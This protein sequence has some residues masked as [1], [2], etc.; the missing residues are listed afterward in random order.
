MY[1]DSFAV[2][3]VLI[4]SA[5]LA[6][7]L[8][9]RSIFG[10]CAAARFLTDSKKGRLLRI[11]AVVKRSSPTRSR[12]SHG[13]AR[14]VAEYPIGEKK[15]VGRMLCSS[16]ERLTEGQTVKV[17]VSERKSGFFVVDERQIKGAVFACAVMCFD[18]L[19]I[20]SFL[21]FVAVINCL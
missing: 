13:S 12:N 3:A 5:L 4:A 10:L 21:S 11:K 2:R 19:V 17:F 7:W 18:F 8:L 15:I 6:V 20:A 1:S 9:I 14:A 16:T